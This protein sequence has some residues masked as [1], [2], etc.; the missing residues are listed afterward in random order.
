MTEDKKSIGSEIGE[1]ETTVT[2]STD[3]VDARL[4]VA[5]EA[6]SPV[7]SPTPRY[8]IREEL[9]SGGAGHVLSALDVETRRLVA[10]KMPRLA[11]S[12]TTSDHP[13]AQQGDLAVAHFWGEASITAQLEHPAIVPIYDVGRGIDGTPYY[14]MRLVSSRSLHDV[15][16]N[17]ALK[18]EWPLSRLVFVLIQVAR[19]LAYAHARGVLHRDVKPANVL[20]G[21]YGE[22]YLADWGIARIATESSVLLSSDVDTPEHR[23]DP[24]MRLVGTPGFMAPEMISLPS[25]AV[26]HRSDLFALGVVLYE[27]LTGRQPFRRADT[28]ATLV[29]TYS[30]EPVRPSAIAKDCPL[31]LEDLCMKLLAKDPNARPGSAEEVAQRLEEFVEGN[32][33]RARRIEE[34]RLLCVRAKESLER[35]R[36]LEAESTGRRDEARRLL[37]VIKAWEPIAKK[38]PAWDLELRARDLDKEAALELARVID[39][40]TKALGYDPSS[41]E[42]HRGLADLYWERARRAEAER[43]EATMAHYEALVREHDDDGHYAALSKAHAYLSVDTTPGGARVVAHRF[44]P[45]DRRLVKDDEH[46]IDLGRTPVRHVKLDPGSYVLVVSA[47]HAGEYRDV[48]YPVLLRRGAHHEASI[49]FYRDDRVGNGFLYIPRGPTIVGGDELAYDALPRQEIDVASFAIAK[50]PVTMREYCTFLDEIG[51]DDPTLAEKRAPHDVHGSEGLMVTRNTKGLWEPSPLLIEGPAR[52]AL[53]GNDFPSFED[54]LW[55]VPVVLVDWYD[56]IAY[57]EWRS[58][59]DGVTYRLPREHEWNKA[60]RG[61]DGRFYPWGDEFDP[62]FCKMRDSRPWPQQIEPIGTMAA[63]ESPYGVRDMAGNVRQWMGDVPEAGAP[64]SLREP[65]AG[66]V[67]R[68]DSPMRCV[69]GGLWN[70]DAQWARSASRSPRINALMRGGGLGFRLAKDL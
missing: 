5:L 27:V 56:A 6:S 14:T 4:R 49:D 15:L 28:P 34:A 32:R 17:E 67:S 37:D 3:A 57:C 55:S 10:I 60:A 7:K 13:S 64:P 1:D 30:E 2:V 33:D 44:V 51:R 59:R 20:V 54:L 50:F 47:E 19:A 24:S 25:E 22:V 46:A 41:A 70:G 40:Y 11:G 62:T 31:L 35:Y 63:D 69:R 52:E 12:Y 45:R 68:G 65:L 66:S 21:T 58:K 26:D 9:G 38:R 18:R 43:R 42:A 29:A 23:I 16:T 61:A 8:V 48:Q 53:L 39:D 36:Q